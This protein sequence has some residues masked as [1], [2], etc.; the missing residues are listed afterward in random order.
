MPTRA[1]RPTTRQYPRLHEYDIICMWIYP[2]P[3]RTAV[4]PIVAGPQRIHMQPN[5]IGHDSAKF[6]CS[7]FHL[8]AMSAPTRASE[9]ADE[10][11]E[12]DAKVCD[13]SRT[14]RAVVARGARLCIHLQAQ[15]ERSEN[16]TSFQYGHIFYLYTLDTEVYKYS[17][18]LYMVACY[19]ETTP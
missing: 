13:I 1:T 14:R 2:T 4:K 10:E 11:M 12:R 9:C 6:H 3:I 7:P 17:H 8:V 15:T 19:T 5:H 16:Y 18:A